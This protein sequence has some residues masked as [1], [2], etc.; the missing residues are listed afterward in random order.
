MPGAGQVHSRP[1][2][3]LQ[4]PEDV[5]KLW[6]I[7]EKVH[8]LALEL[9][10]TISSQHG[11]GLARTPWVA[12]QYGP[13]YP[14]FRQVKAAFDPK[15][16]FNPGKIVDPDPNLSAHPSCVPQKKQ[17]PVV[18]A[19]DAALAI[20]GYRSRGQ[21][22]QRL[23]P[24]PGPSCPA[25]GCARCFEPRTPK[26]PRR[27]PKRTCCRAI[28]RPTRALCLVELRGSSIFRRSMRPLQ[29]VCGG[30]PG[31]HR[32]AQAHARS[33]GCQCGRARAGSFRLVLRGWKISCLGR[34]PCAFM[35]NLSLRSRSSRWLLNKL[36]GL[37]PQR[38]LPLLA[39]RPFMARAKRR[40]W[41]QKPSGAKRS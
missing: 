34:L 18:F 28:P 11:T 15:N 26:K 6:T 41:T 24:M 10:G 20:R 40:G 14:I 39:L 25:S 16:L 38:R 31:A 32:R 5:A 22:L 9:G 30:M 17:P 3:D 27:A 2:M 35:T 29:Y 8:G 13:L 4:D 12:R 33:Q 36:F 19:R 23:W 7:A 1:F 21:P 37:S